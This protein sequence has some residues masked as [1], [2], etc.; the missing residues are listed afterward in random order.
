M[1]VFAHVG[2]TLGAVRG[3]NYMTARVALSQNESTHLSLS[4]SAPRDNSTSANLT[5]DKKKVTSRPEIKLIDYRLVL[6]GS[7]LPDI[8]DKPIGQLFFRSF[9]SNGRIFCH[10]LL[11]VLLIT[12][13]GLYLYLKHKRLGMLVLS[14]CSLGHLI[15][16]KMWQEPITFLWPAYGW[17]FPRADLTNWLPN[18]LNALLTNPRIFIPEYIGGA[19]L[20]IFVFILIREKRVRV[21]LTDG[22]GEV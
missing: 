1:L 17:V 2:L 4:V 20:V 22:F 3:L 5:S 18:M 15:L 14:L 8:I 9:F 16:D 13:I 11:F 19:I 21:F 7:M 10:T 12:L 6:I